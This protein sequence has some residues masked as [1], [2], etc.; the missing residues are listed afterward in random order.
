MILTQARRHLP[1]IGAALAA[2]FI[3]R[4]AWTL[5]IHPDPHD[6]RFDDTAWY[7]G[8]AHFISIGEGYLNPYAGTP[9]AG[10]PP[11]YPFFLGGVFRV[12]GEGIAQ[13]AGANIAASMLTIVAVYCIGLIAFDRLTAA[14]SAIVLALCPG[15][16]YFASLTL[17]EPLF[18]LVFT[19]SVLLMLLVGSSR[20]NA[21]AA[22]IA[23][24]GLMV[25][26][27][28]L[29]RAQALVLLPL[30][31]LYWGILG[32]R[33]R[34]AATW[35]ALATV[36]AVLAIV[37]W[38]AR[39]ARELHAFVP[40]STN[41]GA[42]LWIGNH[43]GASG[44]M[45]IDE[46]EP[47]QP[48]RGDMMRGEFEAAADRLALRLA[49][50][51]IVTHPRHELELAGEKLRALYESDATAL[52]WNARFRDGYYGSDAV[53]E[54]L[55]K[56]ANGYWF[57]MLG[58]AGIGMVLSRSRMSGPAAALPLIAVTWTLMHLAFFGDPRFHYPIV[59]TFTLLGARGVVAAAEPLRRSASRTSERALAA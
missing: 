56:L 13:T 51:Y 25:A 8:A 36:V 11:G 33:W 48:E 16:V 50:E 17:S 55:R 14:I 57:A 6:G 19:V 5:W 46:K 22:L 45:A 7:R 15:Q 52:D 20:G 35:A 47:P 31:V 30:A 34:P 39:N 12:F 49:L 24:F 3:A 54:G 37:P 2:G 9:T 10:W 59:F 27:A 44:R 28:A 58:T 4:L 42:N 53:E 32:Y 26:I 18:T 21:R 23:G 29:T 40:I 41:G 38:T 43:D 1:A